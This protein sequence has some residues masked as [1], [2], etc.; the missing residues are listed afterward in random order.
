MRLAALV[1]IGA[2]LS[3]CTSTTTSGSTRNGSARSDRATTGPAGAAGSAATATA[4]APAAAAP[5]AAAAAANATVVHIDD[6]DTIDVEIDGRRTRVR[7]IGIDTPETKKPNTP[8]QCY[9][10]EA[11]A[12]TAALLPIGT[13]V[14]LERD[15]E[16]RDPYDRLLAYVYRADDGLFVN[17][18]LA[19]RGFAR[20]LSIAPNVAYAGDFTRA[21]SDATAAHQGLWGA[22]PAFGSPAV[23]A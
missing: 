7:F 3:A 19:R 17:L 23:H 15:A 10:P 14:H 18:E 4:A 2:L 1:T 16:A 8:I 13:P 9:G 6:G 22:C 5:A 21:V 12:E 20:A 11:S